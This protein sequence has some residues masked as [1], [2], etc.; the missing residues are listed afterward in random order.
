MLSH[1]I[2]VLYCLVQSSMK[3]P[4]VF[5]LS[6]NL[7]SHKLLQRVGAGWQWTVKGSRSFISYMTIIIGLGTLQANQ[8][9]ARRDL[10]V[11]DAKA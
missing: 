1:A 7:D 2:T 4:V 6:C 9:K 5:L 8:G 3:F 11:T 10:L